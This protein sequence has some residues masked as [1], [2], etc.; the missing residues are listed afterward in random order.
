MAVTHEDAF[1]QAI[2]ESPDDDVP[3]LVFADWLDDH[4]Q[5]ERAEFIRVQVELA[6]AAADGLAPATRRDELLARQ[7]ELLRGHERQWADRLHGVADRYWFRRGFVE[8][9]EID[10]EALL[11]HSST[12]FESAPVRHARLGG[13]LEALA[14]LSASPLL[15]RLRSI[16]LSFGCYGVN[17]GDLKSL[18]TL[19][20]LRLLE[21]LCVIECNVS[22]EGLRSVLGSSHLLR[23][24]CLHL[25]ECQMH[26]EDGV[27]P[28]AESPRL[29]GLTQLWLNDNGLGDAGA[30]AL[31]ASP[32]WLR[33]EHLS[34]SECEVGDGGAEALAR[35]PHLGRLAGL[36]LSGNDVGDRGAAA[37]AGSAGL[38][39]VEHLYLQRNQVTDAG[40]RAFASSPHLGRLRALVL[41]KNEIG[42]EGV[43]ALKARFGGRVSL[44]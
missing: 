41:E 29:A 18:A 12:V 1:I 32:N 42:P 24:R 10:A 16:D 6:R 11:A 43:A 27:R 33:L 39:A 19:P 5:A 20:L 35:S 14:R 22:G 38:P 21:S 23:L 34:L 31:A 13:G 44:D 30:S 15:A 25:S 9:V 37:L 28:L 8:D 40:A 26:G 7:Q 3:R 4:G 36:Y 17:D 2:I